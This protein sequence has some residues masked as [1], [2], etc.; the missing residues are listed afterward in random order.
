MHF[1]F[2]V[3]G[4][5]CYPDLTDGGALQISVHG[6]QID[7]YPFHL[8]KS[9]RAH[10]PKYKEASVPPA[11]W[12]EQSLNSFRESLLDLCQPNRTATHSPLERTPATQ[13]SDSHSNVGFLPSAAE[14]ASTKQILD[15]LHKLMTSCVVL[16]IENFTLYRV[17]TAGKKQMPKEFISGKCFPLSIIILIA[18]RF[19]K[20]V[21][22]TRSWMECNFTILRIVLFLLFFHSPSRNTVAMQKRKAKP[23]DSRWH[24]SVFY[25]ITQLQLIVP[26]YSCCSCVLCPQF[27]LDNNILSSLSLSSEYFMNILYEPFPH[28]YFIGWINFR[29]GVFK[30]Q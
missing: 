11:L 16:R 26:S 21:E 12:L 27:Y 30:F 10:W 25:S 22:R 17:S 9:N 20:D 14:A 19:W 13:P 15:N 3:D 1:I 4:R 24:Q 28:S 23:G 8:A 2:V 5:S 29:I 7:Y 18:I 6:F